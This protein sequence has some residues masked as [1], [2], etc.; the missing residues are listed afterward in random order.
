MVGLLDALKIGSGAAGLRRLPHHQCPYLW[1][2]AAE[3]KAR[4]AERASLTAA[5]NIAIAELFNEADKARVRRRLCV[6]R[7]GLYLVATG[8]CREKPNAVDG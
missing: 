6:E 8:E 7:G 4:A 3:A 2:P 5:T 1:Q